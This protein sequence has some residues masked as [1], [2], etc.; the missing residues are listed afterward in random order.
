MQRFELRSEQRIP[1]RRQVCREKFE[2]DRLQVGQTRHD[3]SC[4]FKQLSGN[5]ARVRIDP[6]SAMAG[7][8]GKMDLPD[9]LEWK[10]IDVLAN[11]LPS[12]AMIC[13]DIVQIEQD[14]A[15]GAFGDAS[16]EF[17]IGYFLG[18]R[19]QVVDTCFDR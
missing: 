2:N 15:V 5:G 4:E 11:A 6:I 7:A 13:P 14:A 1:D 8:A 18:A 19:L 17:A 9:A 16:D 3:A 12:V 10:M